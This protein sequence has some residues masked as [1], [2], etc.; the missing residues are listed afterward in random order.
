MSAESQ[1]FDFG[2]KFT[3]QEFHQR[4]EEANRDR[5]ELLQKLNERAAN[6]GFDLLRN[7]LDRLLI[8]DQQH[9]FAARVAM[10]LDQQKQ[11][12]GADFDERQTLIELLADMSTSTRSAVSSSTSITE[13]LQNDIY[14]NMASN[15]LIKLLNR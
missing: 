5:L 13:N 10:S 2:F 8:L 11:I 15:A 1:V 12:Q 9:L 4:A 3:A 7:D 6:G 14:Q